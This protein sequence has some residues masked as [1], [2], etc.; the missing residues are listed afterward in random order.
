MEILGLEDERSLRPSEKGEQNVFKSPIKEG[1]CN[2]EL[3]GMNSRLS[4]KRPS[5]GEANCLQNLWNTEPD[6]SG[7]MQTQQL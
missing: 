4:I 3:V 5:G 7:E 6:W 2:E 1:H